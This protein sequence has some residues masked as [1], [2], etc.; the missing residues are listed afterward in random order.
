MQPDF[1]AIS[2]VRRD[3]ALRDSCRRVT[4]CAGR[5][6]RRLQGGARPL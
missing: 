2:I 6:A 3:A 5:H 4:R 1:V